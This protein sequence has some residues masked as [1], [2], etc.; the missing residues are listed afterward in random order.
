M[1]S[2]FQDCHQDVSRDCDPGLGLHRVLRGSEERLDAKMLLDPPK[3]QFDLP[4]L[5]IEPGDSQRGT[6]KLL[7]RK[8]RRLPDCGSRK[9]IRRNGAGEFLR[10]ERT[11]R[12][13]V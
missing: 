4:A 5:S 11:V 9:R 10:D 13:T 2:F 3:E 7:V 1:Q 8:I 12:V 6:V